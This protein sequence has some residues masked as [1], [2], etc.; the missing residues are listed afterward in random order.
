MTLIWLAP[1]ALAQPTERYLVAD[2]F[3][4]T[5]RSFNVADDA[6]VGSVRAGTT[7]DHIAV[8]PNGRVA[9]VANLNGFYIS[10]V[11][12]TLDAEI[13]RIQGL[14]ARYLALNA[15]GTRLVASLVNGDS[16]AV[17]DTSD[18]SVLQT[19][20]LDGPGGG[21]PGADD[22]NPVG[23]VVVGNQAYV[24]PLVGGRPFFVIDLTTYSVT[25]I[26]GVPGPA[27][28]GDSIAATPNGSHVVALR[29]GPT[30]RVVTIDTS[31]NTVVAQ[32]TPGFVMWALAVTRDAADPEGIFGY[33]VTGGA[34]NLNIQVLDLNPGS[35]GFGQF[36]GGAVAQLPFANSANNLEIALTSD[37]STAYAVSAL[38]N[39]SPSLAVI[40]TSQLQSNPASA[41][42]SRSLGPDRLTAVTVALTQSS[43]PAN[44][45]VVSGV[46]PTLV[47]ND[48]TSTVQVLGANFAPGARIRLGTLD[49][50]TA[51]F[52]S[53]GELEAAVPAGS[54]A[55]NADVIVTNPNQS[56]PVSDQHLSGIQRG[57]LLLASPPTFQPAH[58][59]VVGNFGEGSLAVLNIS[60]NATVAPRTTV[61]PELLGV[62]T[63]PDGMR[64]FTVAFLPPAAHVF[65]IV[66]STLEASFPFG[67][68][69]T[70]SGQTRGLA[71]ANFPTGPTMG[72]P[73]F[74]YVE[75]V[76]AGAGVFDE[77]LIV[78][79]GAPPFNA[80]LT[81]SAGLSN[82]AAIR[83]GLA[84]SP[85]GRFV[86]HQGFLANFSDSRIVVFDVVSQ[87]VH[88]RTTSG[89][90]VASFLPLPYVTPDGAWLLLLGNGGTL[91]IFDVAN[92]PTLMNAAVATITAAPPAGVTGVTFASTEVR[93]GRLYAFDSLRN[94]VYAFNFDPG[95]PDF[96]QLAS[97][98]IPGNPSAFAGELVATPDGSL[99][100]AAIRED[101][102]V[103]VLD[104]VRIIAGAPDA[105]LTKIDTGLSPSTLAVRP[106][107][108]TPVGSDVSVQP[109]QEVTINFS[110]I[111]SGGETSVATTNTNPTSVPAGFVVGDIPI[112]YEITSTATFDGPVEV[113][114]NY[115]ETQVSGPESSLRVLHE[116]NGEFV[117]RT[118]SLDTA[119]NVICALVDSFS[120]FVVGLG[121]VDFIFDSLIESIADATDHPGIRRSLQAKALAARAAQ[122][123]GDTEAARN[124][125]QALLQEIQALR[126]GQLTES[127]AD[128]MTNDVQGLLGA[129]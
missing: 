117:D 120:A 116:E 73:A 125:L 26:G 74:Y 35:P 118:V 102:A 127:A 112:Y 121:S 13:A 77:R 90:G 43:P 18:F 114:F 45:P 128:K 63:S 3:T 71:S 106:G 110:T 69:G 44:A 50:V 40:N 39:I 72:L 79:D 51:T 11:D 115:D 14:R 81:L 36:V 91:K 29:A 67:A 84:V 19:V 38:A 48:S 6:A 129:L 5:V 113:C 57:S 56:G 42:T 17:I 78:R 30:P 86:Y 76:S 70:S 24:N 103:A 41:V 68:A 93:G 126:G 33:V 58:Q 108:E 1:S 49:P 122:D 66:N 8:S 46:T 124:Q 65:D 105:L 101:N 23:V 37:G 52:V 27:P 95:T 59:V 55:Q 15:A 99:L 80:L 31:T 34:P 4:A 111:S 83:G 25:T 61:G 119:N 104:P 88:V 75:G 89:L 62:A 22:I 109:I 64:A 20:S 96:T 94:V 98:R 47:V 85:D 92:D 2:R 53:S 12:L 10:V 21:A 32:L 107:L 9:F 28:A 7:P 82:S 87:A 54:A 100:Y 123:R 97:F 16:V 60:T